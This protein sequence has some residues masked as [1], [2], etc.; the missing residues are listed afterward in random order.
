LIFT[1]ADDSAHASDITPLSAF[2]DD[3]FIIAP[4]FL[5]RQPPPAAMPAAI[6]RR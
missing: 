2:F 4:L 1:I 3:I 5:R 6:E